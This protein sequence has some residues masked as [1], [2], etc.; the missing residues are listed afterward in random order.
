MPT[1]L[2]GLV[3]SAPGR[4]AGV[5]RRTRR[6]SWPASP[7]GGSAVIAVPFPTA[8]AAVAGQRRNVF[9]A[10]GRLQTKLGDGSTCGAASCCPARRVRDARVR[11]AR[12]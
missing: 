6:R 2:T 4:G 7:G 3:S 11:A 12:L 8:A 10:R 5:A 1:W 9:Q